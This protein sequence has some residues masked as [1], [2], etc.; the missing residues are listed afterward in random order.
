MGFR[1]SN[2][3]T[4]G[5]VHMIPERVRERLLDIAA[6]QLV[7][8]LLTDE[9]TPLL[10]IT[11][12]EFKQCGLSG[13]SQYSRFMVQDSSFEKCKYNNDLGVAYIYAKKSCVFENNVMTEFTKRNDR[14]GSNILM[15]L[16]GGR[17]ECRIRNN[18][19]EITSSYPIVLF[20]LSDYYGSEYC[21][22]AEPYDMYCDFSNN[23][24]NIDDLG[25][26]YVI[27]ASAN[28]EIKLDK[29]LRQTIVVKT[30]NVD[31]KANFSFSENTISLGKHRE[32]V[33]G[34]VDVESCHFTGKETRIICYEGDPRY[35]H[36]IAY[37]YTFKSCVFSAENTLI[38]TAPVYG[39]G[40]KGRE[41]TFVEEKRGKLLNCIVRSDTFYLSSCF[42]FVD[43][44]IHSEK[45]YIIYG[46]AP[47]L[48]DIPILKIEK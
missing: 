19:I 40:R 5:F 10:T 24:V 35:N 36:D 25:A 16:R 18:V 9:D 41:R 34:N 29:Y 13:I 31:N 2:Q 33:L 23:T 43:G 7:R 6:T 17:E 4:L 32:I 11:N 38:T 14:G 45:K 30:F 46:K 15:A 3:D 12:T 26:E 21:G 1:D 20:S 28:G 48:V 42:D 22:V 27:T 8:W 47:R 39:K 44:E 37:Y